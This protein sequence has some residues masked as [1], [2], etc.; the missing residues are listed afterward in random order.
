MGW[1]TLRLGEASTG[2]GRA[3]P[4]CAWAGR[5]WPGCGWLGRGWANGR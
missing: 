5:G 4:G 1:A 3:W 2:P